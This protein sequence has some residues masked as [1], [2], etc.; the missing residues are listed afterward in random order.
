MVV[1]MFCLRYKFAFKNQ[2][3]YDINYASDFSLG[4]QTIL[5]TIFRTE[6][7]SYSPMNLLD[8]CDIG[9]AS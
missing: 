2:V 5:E 4:K 3:C 8:V 1:F 7:P 9:P 6:N